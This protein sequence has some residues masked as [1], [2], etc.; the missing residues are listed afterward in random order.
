LNEESF[1]LH[2]GIMELIAG[3]ALL[4]LEG[5]GSIGFRPEH[6]DDRSRKKNLAKGIKATTEGDRVS[7]V[8]EL[9][10]DYGQDALKVAE[11][12]QELARD[13]LES[14]TGYAVAEVNV[15]VVGVNAP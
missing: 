2:T 1:R 12:A 5:G 7:L 9:N 13:A 4:K 15:N 3:M 10:V 14:M 11:R 8:L 6:P